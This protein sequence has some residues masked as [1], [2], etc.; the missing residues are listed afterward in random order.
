[1][2]LLKVFIITL[3][4][5]I[6]KKLFKMIEQKLEKLKEECLNCQKCPLCKTRTNIVFSGGIPNHNL[7]LIGEAPGY[8]ED[9][10]GEPFVGKAEV[11]FWIKFLPL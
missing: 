9:Q 1:M 3:L 6:K 5:H 10:K 7:M 2:K 11:N 4:G 8:W